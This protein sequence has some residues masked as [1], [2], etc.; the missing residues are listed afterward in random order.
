VDYSRKECEVNYSLKECAV[1]STMFENEDG[2]R[3]NVLEMEVRSEK[4]KWKSP[5]SA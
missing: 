4:V 3:N 2:T 5:S 1:L